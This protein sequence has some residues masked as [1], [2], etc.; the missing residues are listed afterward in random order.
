M[1]RI[2]SRRDVPPDPDAPTRP[3]T[4]GTS[5]WWL[6]GRDTAGARSI[7]LNTNDLPPGTAH[8]LHRHPH[9]EQAV[10]VVS[11]RGVHLIEDGSAEV[12]ADDAIH[13][14][15]GEWHGFANPYAEL[16]TIVS[17]YGGVGD[18]AEAGYEV[19]S[20]PPPIPGIDDRDRED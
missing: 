4:A 9:A 2:M 10:F 5:V 19:H 12:V 7:V 14:P 3:D 15:A 20:C 13:V 8:R 6:V 17:V 1:A 11:G 18:R 16:C